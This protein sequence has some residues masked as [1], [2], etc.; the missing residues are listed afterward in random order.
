MSDSPHEP[1]QAG[2][3]GKPDTSNVRPVSRREMDVRRKLRNSTDP[4]DVAVYDD[5]TSRKRHVDQ[6]MAKPEP[7]QSVFDKALDYLGLSENPN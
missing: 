3:V 2:L 6:E 4:I 5:S 7:R 1:V